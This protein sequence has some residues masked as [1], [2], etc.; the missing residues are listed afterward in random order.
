MHIYLY[1]FI[2][3]QAQLKQVYPSACEYLFISTYTLIYIYIYIYIYTHI[4]T[5][6]HTHTHTDIFIS[7]YVC[8]YIYI[9]EWIYCIGNFLLFTFLLHLFRKFSF[10]LHDQK[11]KKQ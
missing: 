6:T 11:K 2:Y 8:I 1:E 7:I 10:A 3:L 9:K 4:H 5:H